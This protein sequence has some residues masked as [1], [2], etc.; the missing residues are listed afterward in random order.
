[1]VSIYLVGMYLATLALINK[2]SYSSAV[3]KYPLT[4]KSFQVLTKNQT[5]CQY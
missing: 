3:Q 4:N 1:M 5:L 2:K